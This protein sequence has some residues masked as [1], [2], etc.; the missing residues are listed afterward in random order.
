[1]SRLTCNDIILRVWS[2]D[3]GNIEYGSGKHLILVVHGLLWCRVVCS[4][5]GEIQSQVYP[6]ALQVEFCGK[7]Q[8]TV[9]YLWSTLQRQVLI[10][11]RSDSDGATDCHCHIL[12]HFRTN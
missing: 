11:D 3:H 4:S 7:V 2:V 10:L 8:A 12:F 6:T 1:M 5:A 9:G